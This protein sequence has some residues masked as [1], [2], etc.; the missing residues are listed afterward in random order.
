MM[1]LICGMIPELRTLRW[2]M[3]PY[4]ASAVT[5]SWMRAPAPSHRPTMG[6]PAVAAMSMIL[7]IFSAWASP[8]E[9]AK[10]RKSWA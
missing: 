8:R 5:P 10:M 6:A 1:T 9:P 4:P 3:P 2:K 7:W